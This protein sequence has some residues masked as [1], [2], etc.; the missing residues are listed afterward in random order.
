MQIEE[1]RDVVL[2]AL[3]DMKAKDV[4]V[5][6][7]RGKTSITDIMV[8]ASGTSDRHV[9][10]IAQTV[11]FKAKQ[12]GEAPLGTEGMEDGEWALVD[13]NGVVVHVMQPKVRDFYHL[14]RLWSLDEP[15]NP[16]Q[17]LKS[18]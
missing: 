13:L 6:D 4:V 9:K 5:L 11:A 2:Q 10:S 8:V 17:K 14:E 7:V 3:D 12:A 18:I 1:L 15:D 16:A